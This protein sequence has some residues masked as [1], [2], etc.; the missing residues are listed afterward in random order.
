MYSNEPKP[1][2][3]YF[4]P[5]NSIGG[6]NEYPQAP[7]PTPRKMINLSQKD[8]STMKSPYEKHQKLATGAAAP[9]A[10][11]YQ[12]YA[13]YEPIYSSGY[14]FIN[15]QAQSQPQQNFYQLSHTPMPQMIYAQQQQANPA[16]ANIQQ[17]FN[18]V[19]LQP[20]IGK[21]LSI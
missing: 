10:S 4:N 3:I 13:A 16:S 14:N 8:L 20:I 18:A 17:P 7:T 15:E 19:Y 1:E 9:L 5:A 2:S 12:K 11:A 21:R 6:G